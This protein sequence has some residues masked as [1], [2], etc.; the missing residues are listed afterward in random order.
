MNNLQPR[1]RTRAFAYASIFFTTL[2]LYSHA[3]AQ[4]SVREIIENIKRNEDLYKNIAL[5]VERT[6]KLNSDYQFKSPEDFDVQH[7]VINK[8]HQDNKVYYKVDEDST[9]VGST[10]IKLLEEC[11]YDGVLSRLVRSNEAANLSNKRVDHYYSRWVDPFH[12]LFEMQLDELSLSGFLTGGPELRSVRNYSACNLK[13][14][15]DSIEF[16]DGLRCLKLRVVAWR[17]GLKPEDV[18][19]SFLWVCPE[20]NYLPIRWHWTNDKAMGNA[21]PELTAEARDFREIAPGLWHPF[22]CTIRLYD[23]ISFKEKHKYILACEKTFKYLK[24]NP[25]PNYPDEFFRDLEIPDGLPAYIVENGKIV[26]S[27]VQGR[28]RTARP[29]PRSWLVPVIIAAICAASIGLFFFARTK[30]KS[31][32]RLRSKDAT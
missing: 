9:T 4:E 5:Q 28:S 16:V 17:D 8:I 25:D 30:M 20:R 27:F 18:P 21:F 19:A 2:S 14:S 1:L 7:T 6:Y 22:E 31:I 23:H 11:R 32:K 24:V 15:L 3:P 26:D 12:V 13:T 29:T 10:K